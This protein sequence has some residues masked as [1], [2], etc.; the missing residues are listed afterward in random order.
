MLTHMLRSKALSNEVVI[1]TA[2]QRPV[3]Q[4]S[5]QDN[6]TTYLRWFSEATAPIDPFHDYYE[7]MSRRFVNSEA[8]YTTCIWL[9]EKE[10]FKDT[11]SSVTS[12]VL[13]L[14]GNPG[15]GKSVL[16]SAIV[17]HLSTTAARDGHHPPLYYFCHQE[18]QH[19][20]LKDIVCGLLNSNSTT[21]V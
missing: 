12:S 6:R 11:C 19:T 16:A 14:Q 13:C 2:T 18:P 20:T 17:E 1:E 8:G 21:A 4:P 3:V 10:E 9:F 5:L 15:S 7:N